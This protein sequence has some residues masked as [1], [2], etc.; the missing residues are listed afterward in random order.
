MARARQ[1]GWVLVPV[2]DGLTAKNKRS[3]ASIVKATGSVARNTVTVAGHRYGGTAAP[4][5]AGQEERIAAHRA[6]IGNALKKQKARGKVA[7]VH[8]WGPCGR[9]LANAACVRSSGWVTRPIDLGAGE[10]VTEVHCP[11]CYLRWGFI[12][13]D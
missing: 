1:V 10:P 7:L 2:I 3:A 4:P 11:Q 9:T 5:P 6:R 8:C 13:A 12:E